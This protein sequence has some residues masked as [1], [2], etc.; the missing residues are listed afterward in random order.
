MSYIFGRA[1]CEENVL[2]GR[3]NQYYS[4]GRFTSSMALPASRAGER[5]RFG[6]PATINSLARSYIGG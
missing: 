2:C 6:D 4:N 3:T 5:G 1:S